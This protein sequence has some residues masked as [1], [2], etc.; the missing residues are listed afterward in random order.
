MLKRLDFNGNPHVGVYCKTN[1]QIAFA[2]PLLTPKEKREVERVLRVRV[3]ETT[4]GGSGIVG[5]LMAINSHGL[6]LT[7]FIDEEELEII[8]ENFKGEILIIDDKFNAAGNNILTNDYGAIVHPS[9]R[10]E[11]I[12]KIKETL[13][14]EVRRGMIAGLN[15]VG[16]AAV[17]TNKGV[18]C[19]PKVSEEEKKMLEG[20]LG[21]EVSIGTVNHGMPYI[22]AG[23]VANV[24]GAITSINTTGIEMGR[25]EDALDLVGD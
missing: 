15:T 11:T 19:H 4:I 9:I 24:H 22:G 14:V 8:E 10:D 21:V 2:F 3:V 5:S 7:D 23:V 18:L 16:M 13:D 17:A 25:I 6:I 12:K 1:N 20:V